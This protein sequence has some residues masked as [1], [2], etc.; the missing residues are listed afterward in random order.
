METLL[1]AILWALSVIVALVVGRFLKSYMSQKGENLA[2]HEDIEKLVDQMRAVTTAT[3]EIEAKI[4]DEVWDRQKRWELRRDL[5]LDAVKKSGEPD[6]AVTNF[7]AVCMTEKM[8]QSLGKAPNNEN[9]VESGARFWKAANNFDRAVS[10]VRVICGDET[11][12][13]FHALGLMSRLLYQEMSGGNPE[14]FV[15]KTKEY[16]EKQKEVTAAIRR[17][18]RIAPSPVIQASEAK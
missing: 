15:Q 6:D 4:S 12:K 11:I 18:L 3:K 16:V 17:E 9:K 8:M 13:G 5:L 1:L 7:H 14:A 2:T 10:L